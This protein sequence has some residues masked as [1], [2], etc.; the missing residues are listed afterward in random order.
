MERLFL[1]TWSQIVIRLQYIDRIYSEYFAKVKT[2][3]HV[4]TH[5]LLDNSD[6]FE[7]VEDRTDKKDE[8]LDIAFEYKIKG[9]YSDDA[10]KDQKRAIRKRAQ[11]LIADKGEI[12]LI[13][14]SKHVKIITSIEEQSRI[15]QA[16]HSDPTSGHFGI[17]KMCKRLTERFYWHG[18]T[19][20][21]R[22]IVSYVILGSTL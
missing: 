22:E 6:S 16:C 7:D 8:L 19:H 20:Q 18:I 11:N 5:V 10:S 15:L 4:L 13:R 21:T 2:R 1:Q 12:F 3:E 9:S 17:V 14:K